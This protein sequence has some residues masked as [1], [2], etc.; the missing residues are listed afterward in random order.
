MSSCRQFA[1]SINDTSRRDTAPRTANTLYE[2]LDQTGKAPLTDRL[3]IVDDEEALV[4]L[5]S[6]IGEALG[7][8]VRATDDAETIWQIVEQWSPTVIILDLRMPRTDGIEILR[9]LSD[10]RVTARILVSSGSDAALLEMA[11]RIGRGRGL[12]VV[13]ALPKP[14]PLI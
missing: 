11:Q 8:S 12:N 3:L 13:G 9:G 14:L 5:Y 10:R 4:Q 2:M 1:R 6:Q 7:Y